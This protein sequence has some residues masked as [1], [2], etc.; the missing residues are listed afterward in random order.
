[1]W[2]KGD[3]CTGGHTD[4][5]EYNV[6][7]Q[8]DMHTQAHSLLHVQA[9]YW[10]THCSKEVIAKEGEPRSVGQEDHPEVRV[11]GDGCGKAARRRA[12]CAYQREHKMQAELAKTPI[13]AAE[14]LH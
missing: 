10:L 3:S 13:Y 1:M 6:M 8:T 9:Q 5:R 14:R 12:I 2:W 7:R 11:D 4:E